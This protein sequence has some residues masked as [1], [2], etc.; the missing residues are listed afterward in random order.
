MAAIWGWVRAYDLHLS[1]SDLA[2]F[3]TG[4]Q[5]TE[6]IEAWEDFISKRTSEG[7]QLDA[8]RD[9]WERLDQFRLQILSRPNDGA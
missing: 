3:V 5:C 6:W 9:H 8:M 4:A 7:F 2:D 1:D